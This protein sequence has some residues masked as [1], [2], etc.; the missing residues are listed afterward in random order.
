MAANIVVG[1]AGVFLIAITLRDVFQIVI[2]PRAPGL[3]L[4]LSRGM[5]R[6]LWRIWPKITAR[7][8]ADES[9]REDFLATFAPFTLICM[10]FVWIGVLMLGYGMVFFA[11]RSEMTPVPA[12]FGEALYDASSS[13]FEVRF[14]EVAN[15]AILARVASVCAALS[16]IGLVALVI[17][18]LFALF[19][20]F[21]RRETFV[22]TIG[23]RAGAPPSGTGLLAVHGYTNIAGDLAQVFRDGQ[24]WTAEVMESHL[25]YPPLVYF[26]SSHDYESWIGTLGTLLDAAV[27]VMTTIDTSTEA[28]RNAA[29]QAR[30]MYSIGRHLTNDFSHYFRLQA[31]PSTGIDRGEFDHACDRLR[32][33]GYAINDRDEAWLHFSELRSTYAAHLNAMARWLEIPPVQWVGDRSLIAAPHL[34][35]QL[36]AKAKLQ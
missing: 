14:D 30:I 29:G 24:T 35:D 7:V 6:G 12:T 34:R 10:I 26:R 20:S 27:L 22:V 17:A 28:L 3:A 23:A 11:L 5:F 31:D 16:G 13:I 33:A 19:P 2:V 15:G 18:F 25:A 1:L 21:Q 32:D 36:P 9:R 8:F 4:R